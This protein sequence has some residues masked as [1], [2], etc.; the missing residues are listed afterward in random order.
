MGA[1]QA[2]IIHDVNYVQF[3]LSSLHLFSF[4]IILNS[5]DCCCSAQNSISYLFLLDG[6]VNNNFKLLIK[7]M[8]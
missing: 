2:S 6:T 1:T 5:Y 4:R 7:K 8:T 3:A